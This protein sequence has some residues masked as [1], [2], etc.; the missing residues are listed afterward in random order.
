MD[1][2]AMMTLDFMQGQSMSVLLPVC[3][4]AGMALGYGYFRTLRMTTE[5]VVTRG[6]PLWVV[7]LTLARLGLMVV[8]LHV[9]VQ[10][11]ALALLATLAGILIT[12]G[13]MVHRPSSPPSHST[14]DGVTQALSQH[15]AC[16]S[17]TPAREDDR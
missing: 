8:G 6:H 16:S 4:L 3:L 5:L 14:T 10:A 17:G 7:A 11:G 2:R 9:A 15:A 13:L 12:K 1:E